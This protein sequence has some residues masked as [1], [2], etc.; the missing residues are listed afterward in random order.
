MQEE[1][2]LIY[3]VANQA[4]LKEIATYLPLNKKDLLQISGFGKVK[5]DKYGDDIIDAVEEYCSR[6]GI[7]TNMHALPSKAS[8]EKALREKNTV[9]KTDTKTTSFNLYKEGKNIA[10][11]AAERNLSVAT[12][13]GHFV[14]FIME[15]EIE[16]NDLVSPKKQQLILDAVAIHGALSHKTLIENLPADFT[17]GEIKMVLA[18]GKITTE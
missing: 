4:T 14:P 10:E 5:V 9:A 8:K 12:I 6:N 2:V 11:I 3:M 15:G 7:E 1:N 13:E 18:A 17:Y 16:I